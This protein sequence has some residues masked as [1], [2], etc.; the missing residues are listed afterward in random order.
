MS[1]WLI[2]GAA[3][4]IGSHLVDALLV[5]GDQVIALDLKPLKPRK[6]LTVIQ[7]D[8]RKVADCQKACVNVDFV[9]HQAALCS[10]PASISDPASTHETNVTGFLNMLLAARGSGIKRFVFASSCAVYGDSK[11]LPNSEAHIGRFLSPYALSKYMD[12]LYATMFDVEAIGLRYFNVYGPRQDPNGPYAAVIPRWIDA[13]RRGEQ[14][15]IFG[16]GKTTRD[17][18]FVEDVVQANL[19]A[20]TTQGIGHV[21][22]VASGNSTS[23]NS[24]YQLLC[25][26]MKIER[27]PIYADFRPGDI[28]DSSADIS[29]VRSIGFLPA[30]SLE[31]GIQ[32]TVAE[33]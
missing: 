12:E 5:R 9:L 8:I 20:A 6:G 3:G 32:R 11:T 2:T 14:V 27:D 10:V 26:A 4:F 24:L 22:N 33:R 28:R 18:V 16:D 25:R 31:E 1:T 19:L 15:T 30:V 13:L 17:F 7:G 29:K 21:Y 23:L